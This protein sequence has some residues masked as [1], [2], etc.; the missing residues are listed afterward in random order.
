MRNSEAKIDRGLQPSLIA[1]VENCRRPSLKASMSFK[2][3]GLQRAEYT[4]Q[5][6]VRNIIQTEG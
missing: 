4:S 3:I 5:A 2:E 1:R 6:L